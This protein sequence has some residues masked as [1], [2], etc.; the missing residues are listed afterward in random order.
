MELRRGF[1]QNDPRKCESAPSVMQRHVKPQVAPEKYCS[2]DSPVFFRATAGFDCVRRANGSLPS[3][4]RKYSQIATKFGHCGARN[5]DSEA[6]ARVSA[7]V[8]V[9]RRGRVEDAGKPQ[10]SHANT[11]RAVRH[12]AS[13]VAL[14]VVYRRIDEVHLVDGRWSLIIDHC[15]V[16]HGFNVGTWR[17]L[18]QDRICSSG[19]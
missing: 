7:A 4:N 12:G 17:M 8:L 3:R 9:S 16:A 2:L 19:T 1:R 14:G 11:R 10:G 5:G 6:T 13:S 18:D 15:K